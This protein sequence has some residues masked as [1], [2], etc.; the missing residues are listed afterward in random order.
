MNPHQPERVAELLEQ[1]LEMTAADRAAFLG[2]LRAED[3]GLAGE[4][5]S[6]LAA[7][8]EAPHRLDAPAA[9]VLPRALD[10]L[11]RALDAE[12]PMRE[13]YVGRY[14]ILERLGGGGMGEVYK[15]HDPAL[16][17]QV[18]LK[19]LPP[20][21]TADPEARARLKTEARAASALDH[22]NIAVVHEIGV[23]APAPGS[24]EPERLFIVMA[25]YAGETLKQK[26]A[27]GPL[28][29]VDAVDY[30]TQV[31]EGLVAAHEAGIVHRD[32]KPANLMVSERGQV[33][34]VDF[35]LAKLA[36]AELTREGTTLGT[37]AYMS[38]EQTRG[39][40][41][42][43][44]TDHWS[45]GVV[46]YE[47]LARERPFRGENDVSLIHAI[48]HDEPEPV[49]ASRPDVP[50]ALAAILR[51]CL[52]K[53]PGDR[54]GHATDL[55][56]DLRA[57]TAGAAGSGRPEAGALPPLV[58]K[59]MGVL[60]QRLAPRGGLV[61]GALLL[62]I[63]LPLAAFW[64]RGTTTQVPTAA[65]DP[66]AVAIL[67][68]RIGGADPEIAYL[69][70]GMVDLLAGMFPGDR[71]PRAVDPRSVLTSWR[72]AV[73]DETQDLGP[74]AARRLAAGLGAGRVL[75]GEV[76]SAPGQLALN[77]SLLDVATGKT[78]S[79]AVASGP[80]DSLIAVVERLAVQLEARRAGEREDRLAA[81]TGTPIAAVRAYLAGKEAYRRG[82]Y[83]RAYDELE[84][85]IALDSTF[86]AAALALLEA[87]VFASGD[88][89]VARTAALAWSLRDRL[90]ARDRTMLEALTGPTPVHAT[91]P[92]TWFTGHLLEARQRA[93][94][95]VPD[96]PEA[97]LM[98]GDAFF[99]WG[100]LHGIESWR[101]RADAALGRALELDSTFAAPLFHRVEIAVERGDTA[102]IRSRRDLY[103]ANDSTGEQ[104][105]FVRW[106]T[107]I[108]LGG[109]PE[110]GS[111]PEL[112]HVPLET[113][114]R[115]LTAIRT[116]VVAL[117][118]A[119]HIESALAARLARGGEGLV[120]AGVTWGPLMSFLLDRGRPGEAVKYV[121]RWPAGPAARA[122]V[123]N[124][125][126]W[127]GDPRAA[128][129]AARELE[130]QARQELET[131]DPTARG[132]SSLCVWE[133]W[134]LAH[135][136]AS[137]AS[138]AME[139]LNATGYP[140]D[141][142]CALMLGAM[143]AIDADGPAQAAAAQELEA[144]LLRTGVLGGPAQEHANLLLAHLHEARGDT[145]AALAAVRRRGRH[146]WGGYLSSY[147][148]EE[149]RLAAQ[150]GDLGGA[151]RAYRHY[152]AL[153][154]DP[155][156]RLR[157][158]AADVARELARLEREDR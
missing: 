103:L 156:P 148:R 31:A 24:L 86:A 65:L 104:A 114:V 69:R 20:H 53:Q 58:G 106:R 21:L 7:Y 123:L 63:A 131:D 55:L 94:L 34:I 149:A 85:A 23:T 15:A 36:G 120:Y 41:V 102:Q 71:G 27:R 6:L 80:P 112:E 50:T 110:I 59:W 78:V 145:E 1:V 22:P 68:F 26:I 137:T 118:D 147:L 125:L 143:L 152:L 135:G 105:E 25:Y 122:H 138:R 44:R 5:E 61:A 30:A 60:R 67:P 130:W 155:E 64:L 45:L 57:V 92:A 84:H 13:Q 12:A 109:T 132:L 8:E 142:L 89:P 2:T 144:Y 46:L 129:R 117:D 17:R 139:R 83:R 38:P 111:R 108:A 154:S 107:A 52:A 116:D 70:E 113:L 82:E 124:A 76:A 33:K 18:A 56:A 35:G 140:G 51:T 43:A 77:A 32:I 95:A 121:E 39:G 66:G 47:M 54:Y 10:D 3:G 153:R 88:A 93:A 9:R 136:D 141:R 14:R 28:P 42:D 79:S 81:L 98:L 72:R 133:Q 4:V 16:D 75:L 146:P 158:E 90:S 101:E 48:R 11:S 100:R 96:R 134:R 49:E 126:Y 151:V 73:E 97:W 150:I 128:A 99:H 37:V 119:P 87:Y 127:D 115:M 29:V 40:S 74:S 19:L 62:A 157:A 91:G